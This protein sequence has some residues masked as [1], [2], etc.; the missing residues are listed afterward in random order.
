M[1]NK[2]D[3]GMNMSLSIKNNILHIGDTY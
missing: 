2:R 3:K 1:L